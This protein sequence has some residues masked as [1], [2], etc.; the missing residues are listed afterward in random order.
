MLLFQKYSLK[1]LVDVVGFEKTA[2]RNCNQ[3]EQ[4]QNVFFRCLA[5]LPDGIF[6][7]KNPDLGM[8]WSGLERKMLVYFIV[9]GIICGHLVYL[10]SIW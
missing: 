9:I 5:G 2:E 8:F 10:M 7:T 4:Y 6:Y 1:K 3:L